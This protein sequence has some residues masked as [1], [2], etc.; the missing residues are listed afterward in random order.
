MSGANEA[1]GIKSGN[2]EAGSSMAGAS[3][4]SSQMTSRLLSGDPVVL[5]GSDVVRAMNE[6]IEAELAGMRI[7]SGMPSEQWMPPK[8]AILRVG[9]RPDDLAYENG[10]VKR[11]AGVG[12]GVEVSALP[13][14]IAQNDFMAELH[15]AN[16]DPSIQGILVLR[17]LPE[18]IDSKLVADSIEPAKDVDGISPVNMVKVFTGDPSGF[19][20]CTAAAVVAMLDHAGIGLRGTRITIV[21]RSLV[22]GKPLAMLLLSRDATVTICHSK[23]RDLPGMCREADVL[24]AC[25]GQARMLGA[26]H[27]KSGAVVVDV[28]INVDG[29]G[30]LCGDVDFDAVAPLAGAIT[31]V[32]GGVGTVTT[33]MLARQLVHAAKGLLASG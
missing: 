14:D 33:T 9:A 22:V 17:P 5:K 7:L 15:R 25:V 23:T 32:P 20:P 12:L 16:M 30:N 3:E 10:I 21:G 8:L 24:V 18:Q 29:D 11:F 19:A 13:E 6:A 4:S 28:G 1:D 31:P 27:V 2:Q 26:M